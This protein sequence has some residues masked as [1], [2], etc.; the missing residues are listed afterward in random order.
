[1]PS[2]NC[3][4]ATVY[5]TVTSTPI[6][7]VND[8]TMTPVNTLVNVPAV[9]NDIPGLVGLDTAS[10]AIVTGE[11]P[12]N[13]MVNVLADGTIDY[14]P[15]MNFAGIDSFIYVI[16]DSIVPAANCDTATVYV[17]VTSTPIVAVNDMTMTPANTLV[18]VAVPT[19][20][21]PGLVGLD[22]ASVAIVTGEGPDNGMVVVLTDG[23]IDYTPNMNFAGIDSF[24]YVICDS[25]VPA[26]NCDT[27]TVYVTVT[28]TPIVAVNDTTMTP[29]NTLVN[30]AV[31]A[32]DIP[33]L[34]GLDPASVAIVTGKEPIHGMAKVLADGTIDY[35][36]NMNFAGIDSFMYAICDSIVPAANCDMATV[37]VTVT[38]TPIMAVNDTTMTPANTLVN[39]AVPANDIPGLVGLDTANVAIVTGEEPVHG[40]VQVLAD[41]TI[42]YTPN[43]NF[44]GIDSFMY[45]ICDSIVPAANCDT[46]TV[47]VTVT[48]TPI[49]AVNDTTMT[50]A[51]TLVNAAVPANDIPGLVG[52]DT[53]SVAI[54][55]GEGPDNGMVNVLVDGT[56]DYTPDLNFAGIDS[57]MYAICDSIMPAANCDTATVY[58]TVTSTPIMAVNDTTMTPANTLV[59]VPVT[60]N[61]IPGLVGLDTASVAIVMGEGPD[62]GMVNVLADGTIDYTPNMNFAGI[63]SFMYVICDSIVPAANCDTATVYVTV[64]STPIVAVNDMTMTPVNT[65]VNVAVP[66]ND[67]PGLVGLDT[68]SVA[69]VTGE[70]PENGM[71]NVL[72]D[73][74]IDYT[75]DPNFAG[76][77]SFMYVI[78][79]SIMPAANCD[80]ATVYVTVTST[81]IVAV[82][83][84]TMTP[85]NTLVNIPVAAN[86]IPGLVGL[87]TASVEMVTGEEPE[88]GMVMVLA[89]GTIDYTPDPNFAGIDS[90]MYSICD[91]IYPVPNC[92]TATVS[93][94]IVPDVD[95]IFIPLG[96]TCLDA[97]TFELPEVKRVEICQSDSDILLNIG[98]DSCM[99]AALMDPNHFGLDTI[100]LI[101]CDTIG[102]IELCDTTIVIV[103]A[104]PPAD[105]VI[106]LIPP[107]QSDTICIDSVLQWPLGYEFT[108]L[109]NPGDH[110]QYSILDSPFDTCVVIEVP[111]DFFG[112]DTVC[113]LHCDNINPTVCDT[114]YLVTV[115]PPPTDTLVVA[116]PPS[117]T[118]TLCLDV[119]L[120]LGNNYSSAS[121]C[122]PGGPDVVANLLSMPDD[123]CVEI[124][125]SSTINGLE[126]VCLVHCY[127]TLDMQICDT[128]I[129]I[130]AWPPPPDTI[131]VQIPSGYTDTVCVADQLQL[132]YSY[133]HVEICN[134]GN[135]NT[136]MILPSPGDTCL[137]IKPDVGYSGIDAVCM[138]HC[139]DTVG[140]TI[141]DTTLIMIVIPPPTDTIMV[142]I[143]AGTTDT[144]DFADMLQLG[145]DYNDAKLVNDA[146]N[147]TE[148]L[149]P[150]PD[151]TSV[152]ITPYILFD[153][154]DMV[155]VVN[156]Y[157]MLGFEICDTTRIMVFSE[158]DCPTL[159]CRANLQLSLNQNCERKITPDLLIT[160]TYLYDHLPDVYSV[161][162][163]YGNGIR[164]P[165]NTLT[166]QHIGKKIRAIVTQ[167]NRPCPGG[168]CY[169][170]IMVIGEKRPVIKGT[171][172]KTLYC[173][174]PFLSLVPTDADYPRPT[175]SQNCGSSALEVQFAGEWVETYDCSLGDQDTVKVIYREWAAISTDGIRTSAFDTIVVIRPPA[176][177]VENTFC[178]DADT[179]YC[180]IGRFGPFLILPD[181]CPED[182]ETDCDTIYFLNEDGTAARFDDKCGL[183]VHVD[184][185]SFGSD[186]CT[187]QSRYRVEIKQSCYGMGQP[188]NGGCVVPPGDIQING[189]IGEPIYAVCEF[190]LSDIDTLAPRLACKY[191]HY[192]DENLLWPAMKDDLAP[193]LNTHCYDVDEPVIVVSTSDHDCSA[194]TL[195][196]PICVYEDWSGVQLVK[197]RIEGVGSY[198]L[199]ASTDSCLIDSIYEGICYGSEESISLPKSEGP[200]PVIYEVYDGCH[201]LATYTCYILVKD[202]IA[203][204]AVSD[205]GVTVSLSSKK[206]W[207][208][209]EVFDRVS[210]DN[211]GVN[212][213]VARRADWAT[214]C[215][216]LCDSLAYCYVGEHG[217]TLWGAVLEEDKHRDS[218]E[219]HYAKQ[220]TWWEND[221]IECGNILWNA[222]QYDL[223]RYGTQHCQAPHNDFDN[224][225][226]RHLFEEA[227]QVD[228]FAEKFKPVSS[229][230]IGC[231]GELSIKDLM[232]EELK[233][234]IDQMEQIGGGW[235]DQVPFDCSDACGPVTV[236]LLVMDYWC[237]WS[238]SWTEVWVEDKTPVK[239]V[240]DVD[241]EVEISCSTYKSEGLD[242]LVDLAQSGDEQAMAELDSYFGGYEKGWVDPY[243]NYV[244]AEGN[245]IE[246]SI[247]YVDVASCTCTTEMVQVRAYDDHLGYI[248]KDSVTSDCYYTPD[249]LTVN[250]GIVAVNCGSNVQCTQEIW[251]E[252]DHCGLGYIFRKW[253]MWQGCPP[254]PSHPSNHIADTIT[255]V[256]RIWVGNNCDLSKYMFSMPG[257]TT[258]DACAIEYGN[259]NGLVSGGADPSI[260]GIPEYLF[261]DDCRIVGLARNDKVYKVVGG[262]EACFKII[263]TWY[264]ADWCGGK[265]EN[266]NWW[267]DRDLVVDSFIQKIIV[268]DTFAPACIITG[269]VGDGES[270]DAAGCAY[271]FVATVQVTDECGILA[272]AYEL[273]EISKDPVTVASGSIESSA[274]TLEISLPKLTSGSY[275][276]RV[277]TTDGCQNEGYCH[278]NFVLITGKKPAPVCVTSITATL[279]AMDLD[280]DGV[281]DTAM[282]V[283]WAEE[284]D[285]SSLPACGGEV[286]ELAFRIDIMDG[287]GDDT[288][289][290][291]TTFITVNCNNIPQVPVRLWVIDPSGSF[292]FCDVIL[293]VDDNT[294]ACRDV[295]S[296]GTD[297]IQVSDGM[298]VQQQVDVRLNS[299]GV[300]V[301][302]GMGDV[303]LMD[304]R[305]ENGGGFKLYQNR[306][307][308]FEEE[309]SIGFYLPKAASA[310]L[311]IYDVT[312]R[313]L[314]VIE[315]DYAKGYQEVEVHARDI[316]TRGMLYY[317]LDT[318]KF[319]ATKRM[320]LEN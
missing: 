109:C 174:D 56:I 247:T 102:D 107:G 308:P 182:G 157:N 219:A 150:S 101:L 2:A 105:T 62:N 32:N 26:A 28:S 166:R 231:E 290:D 63:D 136:N 113:V 146:P 48:S 294:G 91:S 281:I 249:T 39:V 66:A 194:H 269:P 211:C 35:T 130:V 17:T 268:R 185:R 126:S 110:I 262:D 68:A 312:G 140:Q 74:T 303:G 88:N 129:I 20:D 98:Q 282:A 301:L 120:Q 256:Q 16:C 230:R 147:L 175:A 214:S 154:I 245:P 179:L 138:I 285:A 297:T 118:D 310:T 99:T 13:G 133:N 116:I 33:G 199:H 273:M 46:A 242:V 103:F 72:V 104:P 8:T 92:D 80:T 6:M 255:R 203:P 124:V 192:A 163:E 162:L 190:W 261:D 253:K 73:G 7:A 270:I 58:V 137:T 158:F 207:V 106:T 240:R 218:I 234:L 204:T 65:L 100:C 127:D 149:L 38:S 82:N 193:G 123:N 304:N 87:D 75:P 55:M 51:N 122:D 200:I 265:P 280:N 188:M 215:V 34:V 50:P 164:I 271:D 49:V 314:K 15:N 41:G 89:D 227:M 248:W 117:T 229:H 315:G 244:D 206:V 260:T 25:I 169:T 144:V 128:T 76:I 288:Y 96:D 67:I 306:P 95:T 212:L 202:R 223:M 59:N 311:R 226:F 23:T 64:T 295:S 277:R 252:F 108:G 153:G 316:N 78:C 30:V 134:G 305:I 284:F 313:L 132:G 22:T 259:G 131:I 142:N 276:L 232:E 195:L 213:L 18:N 114:T 300:I 37:Y 191:D 90:F 217:D 257:D 161:V 52:L 216:D 145:M 178:R 4:T 283:V 40:M 177:A 189:D 81:P 220:L 125:T 320:V 42:D 278:Y 209:A 57:F 79:D 5:V 239:I 183:L 272:Y 250:T 173:L 155:S 3:D 235:S 184:K 141:C 171:G 111:D 196:P 45:V 246:R 292:D 159:S 267:Q 198:I 180:G 243:G 172:S 44:A 221:G 266:G 12:D 291:D 71:V 143:D 151:D 167:Q 54:V 298:Q 60:A 293:Q 70:E 197:A 97:M 1:M 43:M 279:N 264:V 61:D 84:M 19:N 31:P 77:D 299:D 287:T 47:Y 139:Y 186:G 233:E 86:D 286:D 14:T 181:V 119:L 152:S 258:I 27:A 9:E 94:F 225:A 168:S 318:D 115:V 319:I 83:D 302:D 251:S 238:K 210:W 307:N 176:I 224:S 85:E 165:G 205:K 241:P 289:L 10:V 222:W 274:N 135:H 254:D 24:M 29:A 69:I 236:E 237:N 201:N 296:Q 160:D 36:P 121:I 275:Q 21:I 93:I 228:D 208:K 11:G 148:I 317:Q 187:E 309:T 156:C 170:E 112:S 263:R 53:A